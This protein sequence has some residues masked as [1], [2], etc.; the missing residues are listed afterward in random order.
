MQKIHPSLR[1]GGGISE[2]AYEKPRVTD[3]YTVLG[4]KFIVKRC[5]LLVTL[6]T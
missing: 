6:E 1:I 5:E 3:T 2:S 4:L